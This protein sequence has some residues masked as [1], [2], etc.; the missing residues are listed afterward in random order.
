MNKRIEES[1][2]LELV[3]EVFEEFKALEDSE[4]ASATFSSR[5]I[6]LFTKYIPDSPKSKIQE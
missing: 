5:Y 6:D 4:V 3:W 2:A 1:G